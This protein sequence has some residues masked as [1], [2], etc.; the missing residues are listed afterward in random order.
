[1]DTETAIRLAACIVF[2][3]IGVTLFFGFVLLMF[4][5]C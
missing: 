5:T 3:P 1:M 4:G 2:L